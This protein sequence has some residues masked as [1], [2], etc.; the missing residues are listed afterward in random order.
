ML[1]YDYYAGTYFESSIVNVQQE[2]RR[3]NQKLSQEKATMDDG[4][5]CWIIFL[6]PNS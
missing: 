3:H 6:E 1:F 5:E 2:A 4:L